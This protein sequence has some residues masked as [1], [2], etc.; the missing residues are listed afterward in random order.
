[1]ASV[2]EK[3]GCARSGRTPASSQLYELYV[4]IKSAG[5]GI[6]GRDLP[7]NKWETLDGNGILKDSESLGRT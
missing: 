4:Q 2:V 3:R 5:N 7:V 1:M 6:W